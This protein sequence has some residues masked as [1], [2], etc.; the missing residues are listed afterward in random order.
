MG[1]SNEV[2]AVR[3]AESSLKGAAKRVR[4]DDLDRPNAP[5]SLWTEARGLPMFMAVEHLS[6]PQNRWVPTRTVFPGQDRISDDQVR[7]TAA[8]LISTARASGVESLPPLTATFH[9]G[10][11]WGGEVF[12]TKDARALAAYAAMGFTHVPVTV[13]STHRFIDARLHLP[14]PSITSPTS[15]LRMT[16]ARMAQNMGL[17][18]QKAFPFEVRQDRALASLWRVHD[19]LR[20]FLLEGELIRD[21]AAKHFTATIKGTSLF[22]W[23]MDE[24]LDVIR[25]AFTTAHPHQARHARVPSIPEGEEWTRRTSLPPSIS[26][27]E[28]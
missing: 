26:S 6:E 9:L 16:S 3:S 22:P 8:S 20:D 4:R 25:Q 13:A 10:S 11:E 23:L 27:D 15:R 2:R 5:L 19:C 12:G 28:D 21:D 18:S 24:R 1:G 7:E 17:K 14:F